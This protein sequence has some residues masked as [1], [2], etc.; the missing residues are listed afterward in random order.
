MAL[1][2][3]AEPALALQAPSPSNSPLPPAIEAAV[4]HASELGA[5]RLVTFPTGWAALDEQLPGGGWPCQAITEILAPQPSVLEW[6]LLGPALAAAVSS[7][8]Q[9]VVVGP[10]RHP[11]LPGLRH[12]GIDERHLVWI[13]ADSP[14]ERLWVTEQLIKS[15]SAGALVAWLPQA[16]Q[17][18]LR[19]LQVCA[20]SHEGPVFLCRPES[21]RHQS[22][23][24]PLRVLA[25]VGLDWELRVE[26]FK[27][28]GPVHDRPVVLP[29]VPGG[30]EP[31]LTPRLRRPSR[32]I[33][34]EVVDV[35]GSPPVAAW[36][37]RRA[38]V[39]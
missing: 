12:A 27:R 31:L 13:Q 2:S 18:Q 17:E 19:R 23:A 26:V 25:S 35:V 1:P 33:S 30:L 32:L 29:S 24:A 21:A 8:R 37:D 16:R 34:R 6:R 39:L 14:A 11:H 20:Q 38:P 36:P 4:W 10:P 22:S 3:T 7:G 15:N 9:V 5:S 28:R